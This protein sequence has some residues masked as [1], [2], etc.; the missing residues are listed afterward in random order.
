M[1]DFWNNLFGISDKHLVAVEMRELRKQGRPLLLLPKKT[2]AA[3]VTLELYPA[4]TSRARAGKSLFRLLLKFGL[5]FGAES[6]SV[7]IS[8]EDK[9]L[10]FLA[11][12]ANSSVSV[13]QFGVL[14]GNPANDTQRFIILLFDINQRPVAVVKA[15]SS[16][17][18]RN[19]L[20][21]E[22]K[23][24]S[25]VP[26]GI[27]GIPSL[28]SSF[29]NTQVKAFTLDYFAGVS[30]PYNDEARLHGLLSS[31][32][33]PNTEISIY[34]T[35]A[36]QQLESSSSISQQSIFRPVRD[37]KVR[38]TIQ[39]GDFAPWNIKASPDGRWTALDWERGDLK[40][41]PGWDWFHYVIQTAILVG[42]R[43]GEQITEHIEKFLRS[44]AF[45]TYSN[46]AG[47]VGIERELVIAYLAHLIEVIQPAEGLDPNRELLA[48][49]RE[50]WFQGA[51]ALA[52]R[53]VG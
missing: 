28:R 10:K 12:A 2:A 25:S 13:P 47:I 31:W 36:W 5:P 6:I 4:Q 48:S 33:F 42:R 53:S 29:E 23:F 14:A 7:A 3:V 17:A 20:E 43:T 21:K 19:L 45:K 30:P 27:P 38:A 50:R 15:G 1:P 37:R 32:L 24:L 16:P 9:F 18:A 34:E 44:D 22:R 52:S 51:F 26:A 11:S 39:H 46:K 41:V 40:G 35:A 49:L 8:R